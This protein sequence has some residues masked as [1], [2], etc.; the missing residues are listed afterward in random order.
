[1]PIDDAEVLSL[2]FRLQQ[3]EVDADLEHAKATAE[4]DVDERQLARIPVQDQTSEM[5]AVELHR[6]LVRAYGLGFRKN[7]PKD[8]AVYNASIVAFATAESAAME[9]QGQG[10]LPQIL[11][12]IAAIEK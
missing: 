12:K 5:R 3:S 6:Q 8:L 7:F 10:R 2:L 11:E 4:E 1:M 9:G